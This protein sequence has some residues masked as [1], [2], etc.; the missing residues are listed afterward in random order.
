MAG[1]VD[2]IQNILLPVLRL[3]IQ[4][5]GVGLDRDAALTLQV[6]IV[7]QLLFHIAVGDRTGQLQDA[8]GKRRF[9]VVDMGDDGKISNALGVHIYNKLNP[10]E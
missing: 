3:V 4:P 5:H 7:E 2:Q 9:A 10:Q 6:H 1:R 8:V